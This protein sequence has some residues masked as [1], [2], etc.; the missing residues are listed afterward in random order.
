[1][2]LANENITD[3]SQ[4]KTSSAIVSIDLCAYS[5]FSFSCTIKVLVF[6]HCYRII[7]RIVINYI[8][9]ANSCIVLD[10]TVIVFST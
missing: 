4:Y 3:T 9:E 5:I 10:G 2:I 8:V 7:I 6:R 1:M